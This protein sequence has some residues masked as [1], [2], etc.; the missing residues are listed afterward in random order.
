MQT[1]EPVGSDLFVHLVG[2]IVNERNGPVLAFDGA[3]LT[4]A[5]LVP[6]CTEQ[7]EHIMM[8]WLQLGRVGLQ[9]PLALRHRHALPRVGRHSC[10]RHRGVAGADGTTKLE[11]TSTH[12]LLHSCCTARATRL[13]LPHWSCSERRKPFSAM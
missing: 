9:D 4:A 1:G 13:A 6:H 2:T 5:H 10:H 3:H 12:E 8:R 7:L 11:G